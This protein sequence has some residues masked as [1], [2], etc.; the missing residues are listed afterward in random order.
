MSPE[1]NRG[2][3]QNVEDIPERLRSALTTATSS[4]STIA[5]IAASRNM[6]VATVDIKQAYLNA[7]MESDVFMWIPQPVAGILCKNDPSFQPFLHEN[8][9]V[10]VSLLEAQYGCIGS[11]KLW[12]NHISKAISDLGFQVNPF[13]QC[14]F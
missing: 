3:G 13:D 1:V 9:R 7:E 6:E 2:D 8:G 11:A 10:L 5:S 4:V 14:V 12:Y